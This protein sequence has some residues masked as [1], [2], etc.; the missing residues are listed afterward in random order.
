MLP[1]LAKH[2][3]ERPVWQKKSFL[4]L[5]S[6][7]F[8]SFILPSLKC[9]IHCAV[10]LPVQDKCFLNTT[11]TTCIPILFAV[12]FYRW[13]RRSLLCLTRFDKSSILHN[14]LATHEPSELYSFETHQ[15]QASTEIK[16]SMN[17]F[18]LNVCKI[19]WAEEA[20]C[21]KHVAIYRAFSNTELYASFVTGR[22]NLW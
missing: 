9:K 5:R 4:S 1:L 21:I 12:E 8:T 19:F 13:H 2:Q 7:I 22:Q 18:Y 10:C 11:G 15:R 14:R 3:M 16:K 6:L 20:S 17:T